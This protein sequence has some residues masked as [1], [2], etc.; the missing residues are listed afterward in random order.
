MRLLVSEQSVDAVLLRTANTLRELVPCD[1]VV[2]WEL[3]GADELRPALIDGDDEAEMRGLRI[4]LGH[5]ITGA[6]VRDQVLIVSNDAHTD[7][8]A[9]HV[10]GTEL[11][12]E[13]II[14]VP[15]TARGDS[16]GALSLYRRGRARAFAQGEVELVEHFADVAAIALHNART[17]AELERL[18]STDD[19]TGLANRRRFHEELRRECA[20]A[21]RHGTP[22]SLLLLDLDNFKKINDSHGHEVG[23]RVLRSVATL[24]TRRVRA[25][26]VAARIGGDEFAVLLPQ[27][28]E[29]QAAELARGLARYLE[30]KAESPVPLSVTIGAAS[31]PRSACGELLSEADHLLYAEKRRRHSA[32]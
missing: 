3:A 18:A 15:L 27:T 9:A 28:D 17:M 6:A 14:C 23:D 7:A 5:G 10:P 21:G 22:L 1:D 11:T 29:R 2:I 30:S 13:A 32:A 31:T 4:K 25:S 26:D 20:A 24:L 8:R 12:P 16:V 19:L